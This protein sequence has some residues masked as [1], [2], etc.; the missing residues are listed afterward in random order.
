MKRLGVAG[1][2]YIHVLTQAVR[3]METGRVS[4]PP[5][6]ETLKDT[7]VEE[8]DMPVPLFEDVPERNEAI[9]ATPPLYF[10]PLLPNAP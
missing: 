2:K 5:V 4:G 6:R 1:H 7:D 10:Q 9:L 8:I 3:A